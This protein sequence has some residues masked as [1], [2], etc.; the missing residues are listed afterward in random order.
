VET[1][2]GH[3]FISY[4]REDAHRVDRLQTILEAAGVPVWRDTADLWPGEDW[5]TRI[6][7]AITKNALAFVVCF[8]EHSEAGRMS[9]QKEELR[10]AVDQMRL[11][12]PDQSWLIPVRFDDIDL[13]DIEIGGGRTLN[14]I[15]SA[16][17]LDE[18]WDQGAARLVAG[19]LRAL[20][21]P[22]LATLP[23]PAI[24]LQ[25]QLKAALR[26]PAGDI[27]LNDILL[28]VANQVR[29]MIVSDDIFP[30]TS[31]AL[32]GSQ[33]DAAFYVADVAETCIETMNPALDAL[34]STAQWI[35]EDQAPALTRFVERLVPAP[36]NESGMVVLTRLRWFPILP[37]IYAGALAA[38]HQDNY[39]ALRAVALDAT[40]RDA[41]D[42]RVPFIGRA[43]PW[44]PFSHFELV[45]QVLAL[46]AGGKEVDRQVA[47]DLLAGRQGKRYTPVS[48]YLHDTLRAKFQ[49]EIVDDSEYSDLFDRVEVFL[50]LLSIDLNSQRQDQ[51]IYLDGPYIGRFTWRDPYRGEREAPEAI[52]SRQLRDHKERWLPL[53]AGLFGGSAERAAAA[54]KSFTREADE[55]RRRQF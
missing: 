39:R 21:G 20:Q 5:R 29:D 16:D 15:Q 46:R 38:L 44:R 40:V 7:H 8:S 28:S 1:K 4:V 23:A 12:R 25:S 9:Y 10:L 22:G 30:A 19:V 3:A 33:I 14:D 11:R 13:P 47:D 2:D 51:H 32:R 18:T 49:T 45:P 54:L 53:R 31:D 26:D 36:A 37:V 43:H 17:L 27:A 41:T 50:A 34:V 48:D 24:S 52:L 55:A 35:R 42:G 6:R